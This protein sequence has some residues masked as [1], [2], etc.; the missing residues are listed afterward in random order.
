MLLLDGKWEWI[1]EFMHQ[2]MILDEMDI[3]YGTT[4]LYPIARYYGED[5]Y[6]DGYGGEAYSDF[7]GSVW[8]YGARQH[9]FHP[10]IDF[11]ED[12]T[13]SYCRKRMRE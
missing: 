8:G 7:M 4:L 2:K 5:Q 6:E 9:K 11:D 10:S 13:K 1:I 12:P 3:E